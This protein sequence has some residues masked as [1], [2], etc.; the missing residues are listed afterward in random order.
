MLV[1]STMSGGE[2]GRMA[3]LAVLVMIAAGLMAR[4]VAIPLRLDRP[5][6]IA[7]LL[8]V[9]FS[10]SGNYGLPVAL[11]AFG[12]EALARATVY[13]VAGS[14]MTYTFG[15]FL[16]ASGRRSL[17]QALLGISRVPAVYA[18]AAASLALG[19]HITLPPAVMR[20]IA[21]LSDAA[22]PMMI[23]VLGMQLERAT[24]PERPIAVGAA[25]VVSLVLTP[26]AAYLLARWLGLSGPALQAA[27]IQS[28]MPAAVVTTILALQYEVAP[29]FVTS[30]VF[31]TTALSPLTLTWL[32]SFLQKQ[33]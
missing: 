33:T 4:I 32:I 6:L 12:R 11:F 21:L 30:V 16:A 29:N 22:L 23:L 13:F 19:L 26:M 14:V 5:T 18:I 15:V 24:I 20:P 31:V 8:V 3:A 27:M 25:A 2:F 28:S 10:N 17:R 7:F 1:T 9:M